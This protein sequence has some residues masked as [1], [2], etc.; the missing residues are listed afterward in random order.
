MTV[1]AICII[2]ILLAIIG[3]LLWKT[4]P[5]V[6]A[7]NDGI[8][9][10][11]SEVQ[12]IWVIGANV[13]NG[14]DQMTK[15]IDQYRADFKLTFDDKFAKRVEEIIGLGISPKDTMQIIGRDGKPHIVPIDK[16]Y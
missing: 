8:I 15:S 5:F 16:G 10:L 6:R 12:K 11:T 4:L 9:I 1:I 7:I 2:S 13:T 3:L 14:I